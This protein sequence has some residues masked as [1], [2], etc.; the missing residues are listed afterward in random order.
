MSRWPET[1]ALQIRLLYRAVSGMF[2][3]IH[4][5][6][7]LLP[8]LRIGLLRLQYG[9]LSIAFVLAAD[10]VGVFGFFVCLPLFGQQKINLRIPLYYP[11]SEGRK[12]RRLTY[13][14]N[15]RAVL[16]GALPTATSRERELG[17]DFTTTV[18]DIGGSARLQRER[19][20]A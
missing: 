16:G 11:F 5:S 20:S 3:L 15:S 17:G 8:P 19:E 4:R 14:R 9:L 6:N 12:T 1:E 7:L 2:F 18:L 10:C 13:Q